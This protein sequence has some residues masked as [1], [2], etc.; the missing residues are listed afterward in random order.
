MHLYALVTGIKPLKLVYN[1]NN[2]EKVFA[3]LEEKTRSLHYSERWLM[4]FNKII[5]FLKLYKTHTHL[6]QAQSGFCI[7]KFERYIVLLTIRL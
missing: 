4:N 7:L 2:D 6:M 3:Y 1:V 5:T